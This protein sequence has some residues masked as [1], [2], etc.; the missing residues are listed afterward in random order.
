MQKIGSLL[1][2]AYQERV[3][4]TIIDDQS[5]FYVFKKIV[6]KEYGARGEQYIEPRYYKNK[7]LF[8]AAKNS[9]WMSE[10]QLNR[11][12]FMQAIN[13]ELGADAITEIKVESS[14]SS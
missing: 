10:L 11:D 12:H 3:A 6:A 9:L 4:R 7:K 5:V 8:V 1:T 13:Q 2:Q 14:F